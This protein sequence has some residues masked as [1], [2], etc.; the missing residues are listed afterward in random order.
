MRIIDETRDRLISDDGGCGK[1][2]GRGVVTYPCRLHPSHIAEGSP[3]AAPEIESSVR[4]LARWEAE[5]EVA[6]AARA[7]M[8]EDERRDPDDADLR[9]VEE[10]ERYFGGRR[11]IALG[12]LRPD[13]EGGVWSHVY[14]GGRWLPLT[15]EPP[16]PTKRRDG[17]QVI[18]TGEGV[19]VQDMIIA[20]MERSKEVGLARYGQTLKTFNGRRTLLDV[21]E[22][23]RDLH[24]YLTQVMA[25]ADADTARIARMIHTAIEEW[26]ESE[27][28]ASSHELASQ[29]ALSLEGWLVGKA[30]R[31]LRNAQ[32]QES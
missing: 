2:V 16:L 18:P 23:V 3:C 17:D 6:A 32:E 7:A 11:T 26:C 10:A 14:Y 24:V 9:S 5:R 29:I 1:Y 28:P 20:E 19:S 21:H 8:T 31:L 13:E 15:P 25:E 27:D 4:A 30:Q 12:D 22:E